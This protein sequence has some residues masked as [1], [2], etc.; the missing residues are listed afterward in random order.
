[1]HHDFDA[2]LFWQQLEMTVSSQASDP[3]RRIQTG[4][5]LAAPS[6]R[7]GGGRPRRQPV[8]PQKAPATTTPTAPDAGKG[9][10]K[11]WCLECNAEHS[12][13]G[14]S[15]WHKT[16]KGK[17][18]LARMKAARGGLTIKAWKDKHGKEKNGAGLWRWKRP[19][20]VP[21]NL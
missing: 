6:T 21:M 17:D 2:K 10:A 9:K 5:A 15:V 16:P 4:V 1:M 3:R 19:P 7:T 13:R 20:S 11:L 18:F 8:T 12:Q 14:C